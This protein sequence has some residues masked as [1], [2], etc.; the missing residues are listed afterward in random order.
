MPSDGPKKLS[1]SQFA[2]PPEVAAATNNHLASHPL[3]LFHIPAVRQFFTQYRYKTAADD[4]FE[5][6]VAPDGAVLDKTIEYNK[7]QLLAGAALERPRFLIDV[8]KSLYY[9]FQNVGGLKVLCVGPRTEN[10]IFMLLAAGFTPENVRGLDLISYSEFVDCGDMHAMPYADASFDIVILGWVVGYSKEPRRVA[11]ETLRVLKPGGIVA[12]GEECEPP[13]ADRD[14][15][16]IF[17]DSAFRSVDEMLAIFG[18]AVRH[19]YFRHDVHPTMTER[20]CHLMTVFD[21]P[22]DRTG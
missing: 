5:A 3:D 6:Y 12:M 16:Y 22:G 9:V 21:T 7:E 17:G 13:A 4:T 10:E 11:A 8:V 15:R 19:V 14:G 18:D 2:M 1:R 20:V